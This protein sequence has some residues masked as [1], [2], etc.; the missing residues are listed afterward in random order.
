MAKRKTKAQR[1]AEQKAA[2]R[3]RVADIA[4]GAAGYELDADSEF[5]TAEVLSRLMP[6]LQIQ[7]SMEGRDYLWAL[8]NLGNYND[9]D[10]TTDFLYEHGVRA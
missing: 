3:Q 6:A 7:F 5:S 9:I 8:S 4:T 2:L 10:S 1:E